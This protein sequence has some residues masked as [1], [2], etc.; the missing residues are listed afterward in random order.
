M[1][2]ETLHKLIDA[3]Q[4]NICQIAIMHYGELIYSDTW[5]DYRKDDLVHGMVN[6]YSF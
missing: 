1:N 2:H 5:N 3:E 6:G 4:K